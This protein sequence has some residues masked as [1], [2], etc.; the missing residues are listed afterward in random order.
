MPYFTRLLL[1]KL[2]YSLLFRQFAYKK[3]SVFLSYDEIIQSLYDNFLLLCCMYY[4]IMR[5]IQI[6]IIT[7]QC[8]AIKIPARLH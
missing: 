7:Q 5:I 2:P 8:V 3:H 4:T 6:Y 1:C